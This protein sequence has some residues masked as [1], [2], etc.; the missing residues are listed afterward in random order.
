MLRRFQ[1]ITFL[2]VAC[3]TLSAQS[4]LSQSTIAPQRQTSNYLRNGSFE[5]GLNLNW[6]YYISSKSDASF[7]LSDAASEGKSIFDGGVYALK[8]DV[9]T[10]ERNNQKAVYAR[11]RARVGS[12][13]LYLLQFWAHGPEEA[14]IYVEIEGAEQRGVAFETRVGN[15]DSKGEMVAF[16]YPFRMDKN[17][18]NRELT[19]T[20]YF[21]S[22]STRDKSNDPDN[23]KITT[24][25][26]ATYFI[27]GLVLVDQSNDMHHDVYNTYIWN[28]NQVQ[29]SSN[30]AWTAGDNDVSFDLPDGRRMWIFNDSFY[31]VNNPSSNVFPGGAFVRNAVVIQN[32]DG[33]LHSLPVTNQGGQ[34]TYFRIPDEDVI[35]NTPGVPSSGVKNIFWVGDALLENDTV[36]VYL[37]EVYGNDRSYLGK[38]TYPELKFVGIEKQEPFCKRYEK[39]FVEGDKIYLYAN[40]GSGWTRTMRVARADLGDMSG[41]KGTWRFWDGAEWSVADKGYDVS[42]RGADAVM[43]LGE[44]NYVQL[45]MP[46]MS[47]EVYV[48]FSPTPH[49]PWGHETLVGIGDRSANYW[50]YMPNFHG[51]LPNGKFSISMSANY[52]GCLFFCRDCENKLYTDK[53]WY[54]QRYIQADLLALSPY[55]T[56]ST[57]CAGVEN[58]TAYFDECGDCVGGTTGREACLTGVAQLYTDAAFSEGGIGL[59]AGEYTA[60]GLQELGVDGKALAS[61]VVSE[62]YVTELYAEDNFAGD[63]LMVEAGPTVLSQLQFENKVVSLI[64]RRKGMQVQEGV[65]AIQNKQSGLYMGVA[66]NSTANNA[67]IEQ[68]SYAG[69]A[70]Q[71][72]QVKPIGNDYY[73]LVNEGSQKPLNINTYRE[74]VSLRLE[75]WDGN[76][77]D[78]TILEGEISTQY[79]GSPTNQTVDKLIDKDASTKFLAYR[80]RAWVQFRSATAQVLKRYCLTSANDA[81][82]RDPKL[83]T[84]S[85]SNDGE[86]WTEL[87]VRADVKFGSRLEEQSFSI[88]NNT[89]AFSYYRIDMTCLAGSVLQ[90][91]ELKLYA[92]TGKDPESYLTSQQFIIQDAGDGYVRIVC[93]QS[94]RVLEVLDG[95]LA[96]GVGVLH[97]PDYGQLG[98]LWKLQDPATVPAGVTSP[99][100]VKVVLHPNPANEWVVV[101]SNNAEPVNRVQVID[102]SG[103]T[104][105]DQ[106]ANT[107][108]FSVPLHQLKS[109]MY[110]VRIYQHGGISTHKLIKQ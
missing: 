100:R 72:Y 69:E 99:E 13:S 74:D 92:S 57:D 22:S 51:Q 46:V 102:I 25:S 109:G 24:Y 107:T 97:V 89:L 60:A 37:T 10:L 55:T 85:G 17:N 61:L 78:I 95:L 3:S 15:G 83:W 5:L 42:Q 18:T 40:G 43:K 70:T 98:A 2:I 79:A 91:A 36:K 104:I 19:I 106:P 93:R 34:T 58:G 49:G 77:L 38:F 4:F 88:E 50:Y 12:D 53:Y 32:T 20:F 44:G 45:A 66:G 90:L 16:H 33:T 73:V 67:L 47:P 30:Q 64:I 31:G 86:N 28:Y 7:T 103:S 48:L 105:Y 54:R 81:S 76:E 35:Y 56:S 8:V 52:H 82:I 75:Q 27:D 23:C 6:E 96:E 9:S 59:V 84:L 39:F 63:K 110:L 29:N 68:K 65:Y 87:D 21:Q 11:T 41:K 101:E 1:F 14:K 108:S 94:D 80:N 26:G 62:G 71:K